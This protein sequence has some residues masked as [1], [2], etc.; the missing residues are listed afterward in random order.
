MVGIRS[1]LDFTDVLLS[2]LFARG[3]V[4]TPSHFVV[5]VGIDSKELVDDGAC[6]FLALRDK[7]SQPEYCLTGTK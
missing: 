2:T 4:N 5:D 6:E 3:E 7:I 1:G